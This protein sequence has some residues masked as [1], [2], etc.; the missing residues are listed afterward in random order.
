MET[1]KLYI[2]WVEEETDS[3]IGTIQELNNYKFEVSEIQEM[4]KFDIERFISDLQGLTR[5]KNVTEIT[6]DG[7]SINV[8]VDD[9]FYFT[10]EFNPIERITCDYYKLFLN[11]L[12]STKFI[13]NDISCKINYK[14][15]GGFIK[16]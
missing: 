6:I 14:I 11:E 15:L 16:C 8:F 7:T 3:I 2:G 10:D 4:I 12:L 1:K 9:K 13:I 5:N